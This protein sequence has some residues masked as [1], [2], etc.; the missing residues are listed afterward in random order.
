MNTEEDYRIKLDAFEGPLDLLLY[1]ISKEEIDIYNIPISHM[2]NQ[3]IAFIE[4]TTSYNQE[5]IGE[6]L[7]LAAELIFIKSQMLLKRKEES[8]EGE[9]PR[10]E[11]VTK[12]LEY[13]KFREAGKILFGRPMLGRDTFSRTINLQDLVEER[14]VTLEKY[15]IISAYMKFLDARKDE[16]PMMVKLEKYTI[17]EALKELKK[18]VE[19]RSELCFRDMIT[20]IKEKII[21]ILKFLALLELVKTGKVRIEQTELFGPIRVIG[22]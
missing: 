19:N 9:D 2:L 21:L 5:N 7:L 3:Y 11:L 16:A 20:V 15:D 12:L 6:F 13:K 4:T 1:L 17:E 14:K 18:E 22:C 8:D 10:K